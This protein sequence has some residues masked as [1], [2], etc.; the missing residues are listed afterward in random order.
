[1]QVPLGWPADLARR[2]PDIR[3]AEAS[4]HAA[5]A[6]RG[7]AVASLYPRLTLSASGG[8]QSESAGNLLEWASRFG[9]IGPSLQLPVFDRGRWKTLRLNDVREQQAALAYQYAVLKALHEVENAVAA[10]RADQQRRSWLDATVAQNRETLTLARQRYESGLATFIEVLDAQRTWQQNQLSLL[11][12]S[13]AVAADLVR[14]YRA[15]GGGWE[16]A[17]RSAATPAP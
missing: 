12:S 9:S 3:E 15:L 6:Q 8:F 4:L 13:T 1:L 10:Y 11:D 2:R 14:L 17:D 5:V 7:V 16:A